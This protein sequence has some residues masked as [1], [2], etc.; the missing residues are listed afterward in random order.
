MEEK[1]NKKSETVR[2]FG[3]KLQSRLCLKPHNDEKCC[4]IL[5]PHG[6]DIDGHDSIKFP[7]KQYL[8][9]FV[10]LVL[11]AHSLNFFFSLAFK[12]TPSTSVLQNSQNLWILHLWLVLVYYFVR[13]SQAFDF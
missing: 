4:F 12:D 8:P 11:P 7:F 1:N 13:D 10:D 9:K 2:F 6:A 3:L 5:D